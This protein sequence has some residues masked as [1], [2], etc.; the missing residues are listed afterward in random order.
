[1]ISFKMFKELSVLE[2]KNKGE[3]RV[4]PHQIEKKGTAPTPKKRWFAGQTF[5]MREMGLEVY[6]K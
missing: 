1:M 2:W 6:F 4:G 5:L 3:K